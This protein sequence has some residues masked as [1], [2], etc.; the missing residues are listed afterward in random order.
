M[1]VLFLA[2]GWCLLNRCLVNDCKK[3]AKIPPSPQY[4]PVNISASIV[5][6]RSEEKHDADIMVRHMGAKINYELRAETT[7]ERKLG[8][9]QLALLFG[10]NHTTRT[11]TI[12]AGNSD[13]FWFVRYFVL[14]LCQLQSFCINIELKQ[15]NSKRS[16]LRPPRNI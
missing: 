10:K 3:I 13:H 4:F 1:V 9:A 6:F 12:L 7:P 16:K 2:V 14:C 11:F 15:N 5:R 8:L